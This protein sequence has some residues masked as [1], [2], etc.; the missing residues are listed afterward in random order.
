[1]AVK[2]IIVLGHGDWNPAEQALNHWG[3]K[4]ITALCPIIESNVRNLKT[5]IVTS[6]APWVVQTAELIREML[7]YELT[8]RDELRSDVGY[9]LDSHKVFAELESLVKNNGYECLIL[10]THKDG[11]EALPRFLSNKFAGV[12]VGPRPAE[13][14]FQTST[15]VVLDLDERKYELIP[16]K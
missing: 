14:Q 4:K 15:G 16:G 8:S 2:K 7:G 5:I 9:E 11:V 10:V 13:Y 1:M 6:R 12:F 3:I